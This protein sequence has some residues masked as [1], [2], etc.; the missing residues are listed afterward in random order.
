M[1]KIKLDYSIILILIG[2]LFI[3]D[4]LFIKKIV[5]I[6]IDRK[7]E[8]LPQINSFLNFFV[9]FFIILGI[10]LIFNR[11]Y[12]K[13]ILNF[14]KKNY[15]EILL[16]IITI[17]ICLIL[18]DL[19]LG[20]I[21]NINLQKEK[22]IE[23][24]EYKMSVKLNSN[25][26]RDD[27][28]SKE[29]DNS[30][31]RILMIG[32]SMVYGATVEKNE[33]F[34]YLVEKNLSNQALLSGKYSKVEVFNLGLPGANTRD[35]LETYN[36]FKAYDYD[37]VVLV[38]YAD[39]DF[40][41]YD[42]NLE[43]YYNIYNFFDQIMFKNIRDSISSLLKLGQ[44]PDC[45]KYK[46]IITDYYLNLCENNFLNWNL[47]DKFIQFK[48]YNDYYNEIADN[49][50]KK[51]A[52]RIHLGEFKEIST[53]KNKSLMIFIIPGKYQVSNSS[54][55]ELQK[56][57]LKT[58]EEI[59]KNRKIQDKILNWCSENQVKCYDLLPIFKANLKTDY[60]WVIDDHLNEDGNQKVA[61]EMT[62]EI[63]SEKYLY[64]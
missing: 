25:L 60:Y 7:L 30:T 35:Y 50:D 32:D 28:F 15:K 2:I 1:Q 36:K 11:I 10:F 27:E 26:F 59:L 16:L 64:N 18:L 44:R 39:N 8:T 20:K 17:L 63:L 6:I 37:L 29:K 19:L 22:I 31:F 41:N 3:I 54:F 40:T 61:D 58:S 45:E 9:L 34:E 12:I 33:S 62:K 52:V 47:I 56:V 57:G 46:G 4:S 55:E 5:E 23:T 13:F 42:F 49:F 48:D 21:N 14:F 24:P 53:E 43:K 38:L 51:T